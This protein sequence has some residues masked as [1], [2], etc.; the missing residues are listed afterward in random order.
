MSD[1]D[2]VLFSQTCRLPLVLRWQSR[3][4]FHT[5]FLRNPESNRKAWG[6]PTDSRAVVST[7]QMR[8]AENLARMKARDQQTGIRRRRI[9]WRRML[10]A[11]IRGPILARI[12]IEASRE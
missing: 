8:D 9:H 7:G 4:A 6:N 11:F 2:A 5:G 3:Q 1:I 10:L 12:P